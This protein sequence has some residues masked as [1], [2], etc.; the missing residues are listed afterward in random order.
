MT[1]RILVTGSSGA[2]GRVLIRR[3]KEKNEKLIIYAPGRGINEDSLDLRDINQIERYIIK[4]EPDEIF[5]LAATFTEHFDDAYSINVVTTRKILEICKK[6]GKPTRVV[7]IGSAAE[8]GMVQP[9]EN[10]VSEE[11]V[12]RPISTY[13]LTKSWQT[14]LG[15]LYASMGLN[16]V[17]AR[18]FNLIGVGLSPALFIGRLHKQIAELNN[19]ERSIIEV[20]SLLSIRDYI[21]IEDAVNQLLSV[22]ELGKSGNV[23]HIASGRAVVMRDLMINELYKHGYD[24]SVIFSDPDKKNRLGI[25]VAAIYADIRKTTALLKN[26]KV[27]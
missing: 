27:K 18:I 6:I 7:L 14:E 19:G 11:R 9:D 15:Y 22:S 13:G 16:V 21:S 2:L 3:L 20:G 24:E 25:E 17:I 10:P 8:Y 23:Y 12:L 1:R 26:D 5:H 4:A